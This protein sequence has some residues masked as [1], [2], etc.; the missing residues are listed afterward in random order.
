MDLFT[1]PE[2]VLPDR[3]LAA[4][5]SDYPTLLAG[6]DG[7]PNVLHLRGTWPLPVAAGAK[8][9]ALVGAR[10]ASGAGLERAHELARGLAERGCLVVSGGAIGIDAAAHRGALAARAPTVAVLPS[11]LDAPYPARHRPLFADLVQ[12]GGALLSPFAVGTEP[13]KWH[14]PRRNQVIA[15]MAH[16]V[17]VV[18]AGTRSGSTY[19]AAAAARL[20]RMVCACPGSVGTDQLLALG[21][22]RVTTAEDFLA[23]LAGDERHIELAEVS[24]EAG[25]VLAALDERVKRHTDLLADATGLQPH[26][27]ASALFELEL[28]GLAVRVPGGF[29]AS[30]LARARRR[31]GTN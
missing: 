3:I 22:K 29:I 17:I 6:T 8:I 2:R 20:G 31:V 30:P 16:A 9:V 12:A 7:A 14:F 26:E 4:Q 24:G 21:A 13:L 11:G 23:A 15:G 27:V 1:Y 25:R 5:D 18:E 28:D 19:T 10:A